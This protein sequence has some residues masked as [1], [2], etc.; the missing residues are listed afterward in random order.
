MLRAPEKSGR[1]VRSLGVLLILLLSSQAVALAGANPKLERFNEWKFGLF[2]HWGP[3][4]VASVEA[5][6]PIM[7]PS[8][9][10]WHITEAEYRALPKRF[11]PVH[12]DPDAWVQLAKDAGQRYIVFTAK[13]HDG[14]CMFDS[15]FTNYKITRTPY[16]KDISAELAAA[17]HRAGMPFGFYYSLPDMTHP[18]Y[19]DTSKPTSQNYKGEPTRPEWPLYLDYVRLQLTELLTH[20]GPIVVIW[21]D[22]ITRPDQPFDGPNLVRLIRELQPETLINN[23][24]EGGGDFGTPEERVP[25]GIPTKR[26]AGDNLAILATRSGATTPSAA[27]FRPW[28][29]C[30]TINGTWAYNKYDRNFKSTRQLIRTLA[31]IAS[32]GG[33]LLLDVGPEPDG[34]IQPEFVERLRGIG[35]WLKVNGSSIY[36]TTY[37]PFQDLP[38]GRSTRKGNT[39]YLHI[40][41]W[42]EGGSLQLAAAS[43]RVSSVR[44]LASGQALRFRQKRGQ[45]QIEIPKRPLDQN[46]TVLAMETR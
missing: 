29:T 2:I 19:R 31:D 6:W 45:I 23:R 24:V 25:Q 32:K 12:F 33:N 43:L 42:P 26:A 44:L 15:A 41:D 39:V 18:G 37:G 8:P 21:F 3:Y 11:N 14:F 4:S 10:R 5:S 38:F 35:A 40:F 36:G 9:T 17:A 46:D 30:M 7:R 34:T 1:G 22:G 16:G 13:H 20:Y 28:E 27:N